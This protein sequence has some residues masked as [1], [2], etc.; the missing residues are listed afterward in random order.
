MTF[1]SPAL[2]PVEADRH[3]WTYAVF[4]AAKQE[5]LY[6]FDPQSPGHQR[7]AHIPGFQTTDYPM[8]LL[9]GPGTREDLLQVIDRFSVAAPI[10]AVTFLDRTFYIRRAPSGVV[11]YPRD[12]LDV[13]SANLAEESAVWQVL[14][15]DFPADAFVAVR[16]H[17]D[18]G[19]TAAVNTTFISRLSGGTRPRFSTPRRRNKVRSELRAPAASGFATRLSRHAA[20]KRFA[21]KAWVRRQTLIDGR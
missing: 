15:A 6:A 7:F 9:W 12:R 2:V 14:R 8:Q 13:L 21:R 5:D 19:S 10:D 3:D 20:N 18:G 17:L 1:G 4:L 11:E 16:D